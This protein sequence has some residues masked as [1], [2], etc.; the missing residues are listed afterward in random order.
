MKNARRNIDLDY[1]HLGGNTDSD[2]TFYPRLYEYIIKKHT[3]KEMIDIGAGKGRT[4]MFFKLKGV[5]VSVVDGLP[6][7]VKCL[8]N[9]FEKCY[10]NDYSKSNLITNSLFDIG[11]CCEVLE[12]IEEKYLDNI[13][14]TF[15]KCKNVFITHALPK[16]KGWHHVNC[17]ESDYWVEMFNANNFKL[18]E[19]E[20]IY[21][22]K[23]ANF[24]YKK[25]GMVFV[26]EKFKK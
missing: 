16:Q 10:L 8:K 20:T 7:N 22:R 3:P 5:N 21:T 4:A 15:K 14:D 26:N 6:S 9:N 13:F 19:K 23:L 1:P 17:R 11:W 18:N 24:Y 12:H 2:R 25:T